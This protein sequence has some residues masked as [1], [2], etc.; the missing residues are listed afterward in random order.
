MKSQ[1]LFVVGA[2]LVAAVARA[3]GPAPLADIAA[4]AYLTVATLEKGRRT[5]F[6]L[7]LV[8]LRK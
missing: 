1:F 2:G 3:F 7:P 5:S 6:S 8:Q 4:L